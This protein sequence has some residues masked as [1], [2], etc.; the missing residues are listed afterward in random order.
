MTNVVE[1]LRPGFK[2]QSRHFYVLLGLTGLIVFIGLGMVASASAV[3]SFKETSNVGYTFFRQGFFALVGA[4]A[5]AIAANLPIAVIKK[6]APLLFLGFLALQTFTVLFGTEINGNRNWIDL[7]LFSIQPSEFLKVAIILSFALILSDMGYDEYE[8][9]Q[10]WTKLFLQAGIALG[11]VALAGKDMGTGVVMGLMIMGL[12]LFAGMK[13]QNWF[14]LLFG[15]FAAGVIGIFMS[16]SRLV[17]FQ[18]WWN[19]DMAD[20]MGVMWQYEHGTWAL[21][22]GGIF[23]TGLGRSKLKWSWIPEVENDFIFAIIGEELGLLGALVV[24]LLFF[25]LAMTMFAIAKKQTEP[26]NRLVVIGVMLWIVLQAFINIGVVLGLF[27]VLGVPLPLIS[28]GGSSLIAT[29]GAIGLVLAMER[30]SNEKPRR[31]R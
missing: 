14:M 31:R 30:D 2:A 11:L 17:R 16:P 19:P 26:F 1:K 24:I 5:L 7:G 12:F 28:A 25:A 13:L 8:D 4:V 20:P 22:A 18:A 3:D 9:R 21:A 23:G 15:V 29:L 27:P 10:R 6:L